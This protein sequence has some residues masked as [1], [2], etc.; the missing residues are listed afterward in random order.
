[1]AELWP[2]QGGPAIDYISG[3]PSERWQREQPRG[4]VILGAT[5]SIGRNALAVAEAK[6]GFFRVWGLACARNVERR[7]AQAQRHRPPFLAVLDEAAAEKLA[8]LLPAGYRPR[9]LVGREG[10]AQLAA[11]PEASTVL[12]AQVGAAGLAGTLAAALA[13]KVVCLANKESLVLAGSKP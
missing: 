7:A 2:G 13:G 9:V 4:L 6:P 3:P 1:M 8:A 5:G 12:S 11:L 10:Y